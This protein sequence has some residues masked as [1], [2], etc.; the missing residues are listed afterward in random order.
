MFV[1]VSWEYKPEQV[2][3][4]F[5]AV[6]I[7]LVRG[8]NGA[9][10]AIRQTGACMDH[11]GEWEYEPQPSSRTDT[12]LKRFRFDNWEEAAQTILKHLRNKPTGRFQH[13]LP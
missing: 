13:L 12:W 3:E 9:K 10:Y 11:D 7:D 6:R 1:S 5:D 4:G 8:L 2:A